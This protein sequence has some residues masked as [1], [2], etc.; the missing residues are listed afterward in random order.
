MFCAVRRL[1]SRCAVIARA[2]LSSANLFHCRYQLSSFP[3]EIPD[4]ASRHSG[5]VLAP[6]CDALSALKNS[7]DHGSFSGHCIQSPAGHD[8]ARRIARFRSAFFKSPPRTDELLASILG[9]TKMTC[10]AD[11]RSLGG[12]CSK[13]VRVT[14]SCGQA[15][16]PASSARPLHHLLPS[17]FVVHAQG[18]QNC[19]MPDALRI[20]QPEH[21]L[22]VPARR[23]R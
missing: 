17:G 8:A 21:S 14:G 2:T 9:H 13:T 20:V 10:A 11:L 22:S 7:S 1:L 23:R 18:R 3:T 6:S 15:G 4:A 5:I 12:R 19:A 16:Y